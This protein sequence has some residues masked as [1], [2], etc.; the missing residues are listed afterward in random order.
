MNLLVSV[1][2]AGEGVETLDNLE[3]EDACLG[4]KDA[5]RRT[6]ANVTNDRAAKMYFIV[7]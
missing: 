4:A 7:E 2:K 3:R 1:G 6:R 5:A